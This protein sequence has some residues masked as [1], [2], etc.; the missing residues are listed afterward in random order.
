MKDYLR[1]EHREFGY[2]PIPEK[3]E[4]TVDV[5][6]TQELID[7][8]DLTYDRHDGTIKDR[9]KFELYKREIWN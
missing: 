2:Y 6:T 9:E 5:L 1:E 8:F 4:K 7:H 3:L